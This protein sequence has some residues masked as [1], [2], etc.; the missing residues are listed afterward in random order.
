[1]DETV[2]K[3]KCLAD[4]LA[5][6]EHNEAKHSRMIAEAIG[7]LGEGRTDA[8]LATELGTLSAQYISE[9]KSKEGELLADV[10]ERLKDPR[11]P[12]PVRRPTD[13]NLD[14]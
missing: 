14:T 11:I 13:E 9:G 5:Q 12:H 7:H 8:G 6:D 2:A 1:M 3:L 10:T 4:E